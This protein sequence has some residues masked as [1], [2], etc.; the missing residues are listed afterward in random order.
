MKPE[1]D[2]LRRALKKLP[3]T[4]RSEQDPKC[5]QLMDFILKEWLASRLTIKEIAAATG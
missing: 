1:Q 4:P 3:F 2:R 5:K